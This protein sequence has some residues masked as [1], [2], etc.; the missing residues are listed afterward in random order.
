LQAASPNFKEILKA[1]ANALNGFRA[2][3]PGEIFKNPTL[4]NTFRDLAENGKKGFY[5]GRIAQEIVKACKDRGGRLSLDDLTKHMESGSESLEPISLEFAAYSEEDHGV[6]VWEHP[7]NGQGVVALMA[8]DLPQHLTTE[9]K[10]PKFTA[11]D[12]NTAPYIHAIVECLRIAF[13]DATWW[14]ADPKIEKVPT[15]H[16]I[17]KACTSPHEYTSFWI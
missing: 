8:L 3:M 6:E 17:S 7:P 12:H 11:R 2:P 14:V 4:S 9:G 10:I 16:L 5:N 1:D 15:K 13:A